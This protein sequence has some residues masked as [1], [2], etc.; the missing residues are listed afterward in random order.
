MVAVL[1]ISV[2]FIPLSMNTITKSIKADKKYRTTY[3]HLYDGLKK[4][5]INKYYMIF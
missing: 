2:A 3:K 5:G 1:I 4:S